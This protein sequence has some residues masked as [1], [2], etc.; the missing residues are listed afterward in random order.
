MSTQRWQINKTLNWLT[1]MR[2]ISRPGFW[3]T[4]APN[5]DSGIMNVGLTMRFPTGNVEY[6]APATDHYWQPKHTS[7]HSFIALGNNLRK[8]CWAWSHSHSYERKRD[9]YPLR[10]IAANNAIHMAEI[11]PSRFFKNFP[12]YYFTHDCVILGWNW[13]KNNFHHL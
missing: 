4:S 10:S 6:S 13:T 7:R 1:S 3:P 12:C 5:G 9:D 2:Q 11:L 8:T